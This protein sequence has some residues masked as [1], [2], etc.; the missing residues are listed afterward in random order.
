MFAG[1]TPALRKRFV[2]LP[3][4]VRGITASSVICAITLFPLIS[5]FIDRKSTRLN[6]SHDQISYAVFC[7]K[8]KRIIV[9][10][11]GRRTHGTLTRLASSLELL[12]ISSASPSASFLPRTVRA[13]ATTT[14]HYLLGLYF[15]ATYTSARTSTPTPNVLDLA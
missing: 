2:A 7:L 5:S 1:I 14:S 12:C 4:T 10:I 9:P 6:S 11:G 8:K 3:N 13:R 15:S